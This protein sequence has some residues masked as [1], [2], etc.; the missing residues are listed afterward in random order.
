MLKKVPMTKEDVIKELQSQS[1]NLEE[2][3]DLSETNNSLIKKKY[4][5]VEE[6][7]HII[8]NSYIT[9]KRRKEEILNGRV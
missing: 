1:K 6:V 8:R 9:S 7:E 2:L 3:F 5:A 4:I